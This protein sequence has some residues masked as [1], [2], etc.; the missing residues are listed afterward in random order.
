MFL[1][2]ALLTVAVAAGAT[3]LALDLYES[4]SSMEVVA[5]G[6]QA[7]VAGVA[8]PAANG[9]LPFIEKRASNL[10]PLVLLPHDP[11]VVNKKAA[12]VL[13]APDGAPAQAAVEAPQPAPP[14]A[15]DVTISPEQGVVAPPVVAKKP[16]KP[17]LTVVAV[18]PERSPVKPIK[19]AAQPPKKLTAK[20][21]PAVIA[22]KAAA[23]AKRIATPVLAKAPPRARPI[24][25]TML[26]PPRER[27]LD[28]A[29]QDP[30][31][32]AIDRRCRPG[33]LARECEARTR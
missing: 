20:P 8:P 24:K 21:T 17:A 28:P 25:G 5:A 6:S 29:F 2:A 1:G 26:Q 33:E 18:R 14:L 22:K 7:Q 11:N 13:A 16:E 12:P 30:P 31:R 27:G 32:Q 9:D 4:N 19:V 3:M 10:P 23:Q 15:P